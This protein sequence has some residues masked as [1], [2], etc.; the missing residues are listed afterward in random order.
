MGTVL[1]YKYKEIPMVLPDEKSA[2]MLEAAK[3]LIKWMNENTHPHCEIT[4]TTN[5]AELKEGVTSERT[6]EYIKD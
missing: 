3:P 4:V 1:K 5:C 6:D 2:E